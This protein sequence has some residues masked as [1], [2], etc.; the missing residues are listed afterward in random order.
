LTFLC[1]G[2]NI[3]GCPITVGQTINATSTV[4][5]ISTFNSAQALTSVMSNA[6]DQT[7]SQNQ[8]SVNDMFS[9][10]FSN[11]NQ[12]VDVK[13]MLK[14]IVA[15][16]VSQTNL[17]R[18]LNRIQNINSM[19]I[20]LSGTTLDCSKPDS[21]GGLNIVQETFTKQITDSLTGLIT[22]ALMSNEQVNKA[23]QDSKQTQSAENKGLT[24]LAKA[25]TGPL[26]IIVIGFIAFMVLGGGKLVSGGFN[27]VSNPKKLLM[28]VMG[29]AII[30][31]IIWAISAAKK[32]KQQEQFR[33][34]LRRQYRLRQ[35][36]LNGCR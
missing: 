2:C 31:G 32:S 26:I 16:N 3:I 19:R 33:H 12:N 14:N 36:Y 5:A 17:Q 9:T 34:Y 15:T 4:K 10:S 8:K 28:L 6:I 30:I 23:V 24:A 1:S 25:L 27:T 20:D 7:V 35:R 18:V 22:Q 21:K 11:Q 29:I 13:T